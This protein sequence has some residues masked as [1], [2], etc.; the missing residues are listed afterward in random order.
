M[1]TAKIR[2][3]SKVELS[4]ILQLNEDEARALVEI[5]GYG[6]K[7][8]TEWFYRNLGKTHLKS[9]ERGLISLFETIK[10][11]LPQHLSKIDQARECLKKQEY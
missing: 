6:H 9:H 10:S 4:I 1:D 3:Q 2:S 5:T 7:P 11:E 8:F